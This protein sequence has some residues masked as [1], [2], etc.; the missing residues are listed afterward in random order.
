VWALA[1]VGQDS[2]GKVA[3][4][5][6]QAEGTCAITSFLV[7]HYRFGLGTQQTSNLVKAAQAVYP[8]LNIAL[9]PDVLPPASY[10]KTSI[11]LTGRKLYIL[12]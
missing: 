5:S 2:A 3:R 8:H 6:S 9:P 10:C 7:T 11:L 12:N 4:G 1:G